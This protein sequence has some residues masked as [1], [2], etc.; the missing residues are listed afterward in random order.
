MRTALLPCATRSRLRQFCWSAATPPIRL[1]ARRGTSAPTFATTARG[2]TSSTPPRSSFAARQRPSC[3]S[4]PSAT[5][6]WP[7]ISPETTQQAPALSPTSNAL[8]GFR[9]TV[10]A[11]ENLLILIGSELRGAELKKLIDFGLTIPGAK[12]ALLSDYAN[13][14]GAADM[15]LLP[16]M[17]PGYTPVAGNSTFAEYNAPAEPGLD[18]LEIF[19]AAGRGELSAL[20][21][22]SSNPVARYSVDPAAL[23][24][25]FVVVQEM[26]L[27]ETAALA[28]VILPAANLYEKSGSVTNSYGDLQQV[29]KAGDR[30]GVRTDFEMIVRIADKMGADMRK[31]VPFGKGLRADMGQSRGAQSGEADRHA[32]WLTANNLEP[33]LSPFD[34]FAILDE[35]QRLVPGYNLLRLQLLSGNDQHLQPAA[36]G[37]VQIGNRRDLV[38]PAND[39]LFT[40]GTLGRYSA[41]L[42]DVQQFQANQPPHPNPSRRLGAQTRHREPSQSVPDI[43]AA[44]HPQDRRRPRHHADGGGLHGAAGAQGP[45]PHAEPLGTLPR[46]SLRPSAAARRRHQALPQGRPAAARRRASALHLAPIIALTCALVS[47]AVVPF[48]AAHHIQGVDM[49]DISDINIGLLVILGITSIGVYGI[50]LSGWSS[51]NKF[52]LLGSLRATSQMISYELALGLSLVGVVL[53]AQSLSLRTIVDSQSAHGLLSWNFFGGFQ[54]VAF[55]IYLMAAYAETNRSPFDLPEAESELVAGYHTEYSSMKFA[56]FFMAEYANMITVSCVATLMF[57][58]GA[59]SPFGHL[60]PAFGGPIVQ[61]ILPVLWFVAKVFAFLLLYIWVRGTLPRFRY[62]Q[63]MSFGWKFL[64]PLAMANIIITSLVL[65]LH[66]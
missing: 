25:T 64:L 53:R 51:N 33:K 27:T 22:V 55:F 31:L 26:F 34:P 44:Q 3:V 52:S 56:M 28:D 57:F 47:I 4:H 10:K 30:A 15:G 7:A 20:Y 50:A 23:K 36:S 37:L 41:M 54:F 16:D 45:R 59:S 18:M 5:A 35:I 12:F 46:R 38:L 13:S 42:N 39:T 32:V 66:G 40:S 21:V 6:R 58:G 29:K 65:A 11:E 14:R 60:I 61:A 9:D 24:N 2:S 63:L 49:F 19:D 1:P 17:L 62:D 8:S 48:G 43:S